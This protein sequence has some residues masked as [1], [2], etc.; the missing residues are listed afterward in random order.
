M[1]QDYYTQHRWRMGKPEHRVQIFFRPWN[2][3]DGES[4]PDHSVR[5]GTLQLDVESGK[6]TCDPE[7][8]TPFF[9]ETYD[10]FEMLE[11]FWA[12]IGEG[13]S[14]VQEA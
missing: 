11:D 6:V 14:Q 12:W 3:E 2:S 1:N 7:E 8:Q 13:I 4:S 5:I 9:E 10:A